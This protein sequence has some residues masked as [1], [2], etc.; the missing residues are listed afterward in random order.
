MDGW[1]DGW[2]DGSLKIIGSGTIQYRSYSSSIVT[3]AISC[4][5]SDIKRDIDRKTAI[6]ISRLLSLQDHLEPI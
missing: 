5:V 1:M 2:M 4:I 6:F 3:V